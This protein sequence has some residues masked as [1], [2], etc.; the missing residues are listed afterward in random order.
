VRLDEASPSA[1][2]EVPP[3]PL[4]GGFVMSAASRVA[5]TGAGAFTTIVLARLLGPSGLGSFALAQTLIVML[6]AATTLGVEHGIVYFVSAGTW[7][8]RAAYAAALKMSVFMGLTGAAAGVGIRFLVP[9]AF[10]D[11]SVWLTV[12]VAAGLPFA[13]ARFYVAYI[14]LATDR[15]EVFT[16]LP[17]VYSALTL[18]FSVPGAILFD[19]EGAVVGQ[20]VASIIVAFASVLWA[21]RRLPVSESPGPV[22]LGSAVAFGVKGYGANALQ[23][24]NYRLDLFILSSVASTAAVGRYS[25]AVAATSLL[26][27]LP[28]ALS[29]VVFPRVARLDKR[30]EE[31]SLEM[32]ETKSLRH[33]TLAVGIGALA[34]AAAMEAL[35][36]PVFGPAFRP[37]IN[38][39]LILLPGTA[40][41]GLAGI[42]AATVV[43]RGKPIYSLYGALI[44]TPLTVVLYATLIPWLHATGAAFA[45]TL[46][47][48]MGFLITC[49][50]YRRVTARRVLP[51]LIPGR[52]E[53]DDL[54]AL[55][56]AVGLWAAGLRSRGKPT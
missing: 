27:L 30:K 1:Q 34:L 51:T 4:T 17:A 5:V 28:R 20:T 39:G 56:R 48:T 7:S 25:T 52:S 24:L 53:L 29:D 8:A 49:W 22:H 9:S 41:I 15:Y 38:L 18:V 46:S 45:S 19:V 3:R 54:R 55:P 35:I 36:V 47:Y 26:W 21:R 23:L 33:A 44:T 2:P 37:A 13:L 43:G 16:A 6:T 14:A 11:L 50:F 32:V 31:A 12:V 40:L 10:A 42:L